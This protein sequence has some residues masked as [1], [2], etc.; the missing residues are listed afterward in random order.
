M[1]IGL[2][3]WAS[4]TLL[5]AVELGVFTELGSG[6]KTAS[7][8]REQ[9]GLNP[10]SIL[11]FLDALVA[12]KVLDRNGAHYSNTSESARF[13]D[14]N[15]PTYVGG[16]LE[17]ANTRL[18]PYW[19]SLTEALRSG[20]PQNEI[21]DEK[22][23]FEALYQ[24]PH[25]VREFAQ[26]MTGIS[27]PAAHALAAK[28][29]WANYRTFL[30]MGCA[31]GCVPVQ[32]A[33]AHP[34][35]EGGGLDLPVVR[36]IFEEYVNSFGLNRRLRFHSGDLFNGEPLPTADVL[37][38]GHILHDW[39]LAAKRQLLAKAY[40]ALPPGGAIIVYE[41]LIDDDRRH[42]A[43]G[44]LMSLNMLIETKGGFDFTG[45]D[46]IGWM[47]EAGFRDMRVEHL[48]GPDSMVI[49]IK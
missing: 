7:E 31:Q 12:L 46:C 14:R 17:M 45:A 32:L 39:D 26:A 16:L 29:P 28:F 44:L 49:G 18:Y 21:K 5:T 33:L 3:F 8:L 38:F 2:G 48:V 6:P 27:M 19:G 47:R 42:N 20:L 25:K 30:D 43:F 40:A 34:H 41:A 11:D 15:R 9:L 1:Q 24:D 13:L 10:R 4:K 23:A 35:L 37:I 22:N 36:P